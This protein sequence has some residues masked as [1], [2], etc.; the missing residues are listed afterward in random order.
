MDNRKLIKRFCI[1]ILTIIVVME[2]SKVNALASGLEDLGKTV[3]GSLLTNKLE[4]EDITSVLTRGNILNKGTAK[5]INPKDG[6][7]SASGATV[8]HVVCDVLYLKLVIQQERNN[9]W[10]DYAI[11]DKEKESSSLFVDTITV[12]AEKGYYYRVQGT[13]V[14][15]EGDLTEAVSTTDGIW[16]D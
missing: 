5:C 8:A 6:N 13:H 15:K 11:L 7:V 10:Y 2:C 12:P 1:T 9:E 16:I 14:A 3:D 4:V